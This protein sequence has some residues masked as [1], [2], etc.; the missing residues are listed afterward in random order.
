MEM[1]SHR[2]ESVGPDD[3]TSGCRVGGMI[4]ESEIFDDPRL[5][6]NGGPV[7]PNGGESDFV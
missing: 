4:E 3:P 2:E 5:L 7:D 6:V 1:P